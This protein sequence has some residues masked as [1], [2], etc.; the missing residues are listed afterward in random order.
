MLNFIIVHIMTHKKT[1]MWQLNISKFHKISPH[2]D[3]GLKFTP[4][5]LFGIIDVGE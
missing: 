5:N 1:T 2:C 4:F 3:L